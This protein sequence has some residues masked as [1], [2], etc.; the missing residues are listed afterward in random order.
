MQATNKFYLAAVVLSEPVLETVRRELR[1]LSDAKIEISELRDALMQEVIKREVTEGE[2]ADAARKKVAKTAG[3][4][5]RVKK[6]KEE[7]VAAAEASPV[8]PVSEILTSP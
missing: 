7:N 3:K 8:V 2:K 4:M 5:L 1:R 6:E